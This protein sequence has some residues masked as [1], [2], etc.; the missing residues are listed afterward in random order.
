V[1]VAV[2]V[3][4]ALMG[5]SVGVAVGPSVADKTG[6]AVAVNVMDGV[7]FRAEVPEGDGWTGLV[8]AGGGVWRVVKTAVHSGGSVAKGC[9]GLGVAVGTSVG[10]GVTV[11]WRNG[12]GTNLGKK[13]N[14]P[15][16]R[17]T[18]NAKYTTMAVSM[19]QTNPDGAAREEAG[20]LGISQGFQSIA[21]FSNT[22]QER[23]KAS[24]ERV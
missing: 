14:S 2:G 13:K 24:W 11:G 21:I 9:V 16:I 7:A 3:A 5:V 17:Q 8:R 10:V 15:L 19:S 23:K 22:D 12:A 4:L 6:E 1:G 18:I 20:L